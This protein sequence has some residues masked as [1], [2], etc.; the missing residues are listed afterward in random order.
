MG[1][2]EVPEGKHDQRAIQVWVDVDVGIA[3][4][5][6]YLNTIPGVLTHASCQGTI[7]EGGPRPYRA[8][9]MAT[10]TEE[11]E[12][13]LRLEFDITELGERWGYVHPRRADT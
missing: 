12:E 10:W 6:L 2:N 3:D 11:I 5:V 9:V 8:Q 13:R 7:G 1:V 4:L